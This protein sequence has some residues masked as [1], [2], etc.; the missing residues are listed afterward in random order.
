M[1]TS[2]KQIYA[3]LQ[4]DE[5]EIKVLVAEYYN[6]RFNIIRYEKVSSTAVSGYKVVDKQQLSADIKALI[7]KASKSVGATI[8]KVLLVLPAYNFKR[9]PLTS[10]VYCNGGFV[11]KADVSR[12]I[13]NSLRSNVD[14]DVVV[15]N[16]VPVKYVVNGISSRRLPEKEV[17]D[18]MS[19]DID[20]LCCDKEMAYDYVAA[21]ENAGVRV[22]DVC[23][24]TYA[25]ASEAALTSEASK[26]N[27]I[28]LDVHNEVTY[29]SLLTKGKLVS[30]EIVFEGLQ[31]MINKVYDKYRIPNDAIARL[32]KYN[33]SYEDE[34]EC[35]VYAWNNNDKAESITNKEISQLVLEPLDNFV[36]KLVAMCAP[37]I[38]KGE[39]SIFLT[40]EG[41]EMAALVKKLKQASDVDVRAYY[42]ETIGVRDANLTALYGTMIAYRDK[43]V[44]DNL[45]VSCL[46]L[47]E[48]DQVIDKR[49]ID[50]EGATLTTKIKNLFSSILSKE[51]EQ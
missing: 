18:D 23:L 22:L 50:S 28:L 5:N 36:E 7:D 39:V 10:K 25:I 38:E 24:N 21:I 45:N 44:M 37:I 42:P 3:S 30:S 12:A 49:D 27:V 29:L 8:E 11:N 9:F 16:P 40:G 26:R 19:V 35:V 32:L 51:D 14:N 1:E 6:T 41:E 33:V 31:T 46:D 4:I 2:I 15:I 20:L 17:C 47:L 43:V 34:D 13:S 48:Y